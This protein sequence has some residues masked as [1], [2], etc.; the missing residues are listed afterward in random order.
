M[1]WLSRLLLLLLASP[2]AIAAVNSTKTAVVSVPPLP[3][4][5]PHASVK[6]QMYLLE[7]LTPS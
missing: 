4:G 1:A 6:S 3:L 7:V 5:T 2:A